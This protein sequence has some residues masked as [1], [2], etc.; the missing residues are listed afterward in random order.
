MPSETAKTRLL[1]RLSTSLKVGI[2]G[3]PNVGKSTFFNVLTSN[4]IPAENHPFC[5]IDPNES[6]CP[7]PDERLDW[8]AELYKTKKVPAFLNVVDIAG[9][10]EGAHEGQG[11]GNAF[12]SHISSCDAIF[13]MVRA[14]DDDNVVHVSSEV[15]PSKDMNTITNELIMKDLKDLEKKV[16]QLEKNARSNT[17]E[18][19]F[20]FDTVTKA[21]N[22]LKNEKKFIRHADWDDNEAEVLQKYLLITAKPVI[23]LINV[24]AKNFIKKTVK[25]E[26]ILK[27]KEWVKNNDPG[28]LMISLSANFEKQL[29]DAKSAEEKEALQ[30]NGAK[31]SLEKIIKEGFKS[32]GLEYFFTAGP[33]EAK[34]WIIRSGSKAP[35]AAG[36]IHTDFERGFI[37][38][39]VMRYDD[40]KEL[41]SVAKVKDQG[42]YMIRGKEYVVEDGDILNFK[43]N[44]TKKK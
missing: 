16:V 38:A 29:V 6:R 4:S 14:F 25:K 8:L 7:V 3:L 44:V 9:L 10:I 21:I 37:K 1:G 2:V 39:E 43:F 35:Q 40:L 18:A 23:Y 33:K 5:T 32:L 11:L 34:C 20:E 17:K 19:V 13:H 36:R 26:Y 31:S 28:A 15:N 42:K 27:I 24:S 12:L 41:G 30:T 22:F